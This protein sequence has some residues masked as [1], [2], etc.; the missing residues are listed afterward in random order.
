VT[1]AAD[2]APSFCELLSFVLTGYRHIESESYGLRMS[3]FVVGRR[4]SRRVGALHDFGASRRRV[5]RG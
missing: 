4:H 3:Y 2:S 5:S 1:G